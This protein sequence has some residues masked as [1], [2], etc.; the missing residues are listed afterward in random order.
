MEWQGAWS[1]RAPGCAAP[2]AKRVTLCRCEACCVRHTAL[3]SALLFSALLFP[4]DPACPRY[5]MI[6]APSEQG[7]TQTAPGTTK[8]SNTNRV[9]C[10]QEE[11][12]VQP[13]AAS[14]RSSL[15]GA[16]SRASLR[17]CPH[18]G[19]TRRFG[20][21]NIS[22]AADKQTHTKNGLE[23]GSHLS[24]PGQ[25]FLASLGS[26]AP[27]MASGGV[28]LER[29][30]RCHIR[31]CL[32]APPRSDMMAAQRKAQLDVR[33]F[34]GEISEKGGEKTFSVLIPALGSVSNAVLLSRLTGGHAIS[35][36]SSIGQ[37]VTLMGPLKHIYLS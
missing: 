14:V 13:Q 35:H 22:V 15:A 33:G 11:T 2:P 12:D 17:A 21:E 5:S 23:L 19:C 20:G 29:R 4:P 16:A 36:V 8:T 6:P 28:G 24:R 10:R 3:F 34:R 7:Q 25:M 37:G 27:N 26:P 9:P 30:S 32:R 31:S 18:Y 1:R